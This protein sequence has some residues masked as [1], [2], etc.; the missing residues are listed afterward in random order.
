MFLN[1]I[2]Y[3]ILFRIED[4]AAARQLASSRLERAEK[5]I[6]AVGG[7]NDEFHSFIRTKTGAC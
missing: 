6:N 7:N 1:R 3:R 2:I 4:F 5:F